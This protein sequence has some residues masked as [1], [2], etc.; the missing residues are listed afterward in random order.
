MHCI[1]ILLTEILEAGTDDIHQVDIAGLA[2]L[3]WAARTKNIPA[4][5]LLLSHKADPNNVPEAS[6]LGYR[7]STEYYCPKEYSAFDKGLH[8]A[9]WWSPLMYACQ[10]GSLE[11]VQLLSDAWLNSIM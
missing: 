2:P 7:W 10:A 3:M 8:P 1:H 4:L 6:H 9:E 11:A 5:K